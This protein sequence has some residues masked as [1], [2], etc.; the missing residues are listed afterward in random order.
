MHTENDDGANTERDMFHED[1]RIDGSGRNS[2]TIEQQ[3]A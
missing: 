3:K 1:V 2:K